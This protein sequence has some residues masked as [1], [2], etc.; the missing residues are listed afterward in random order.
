MLLMGGVNTAWWQLPA[1]SAQPPALVEIPELPPIPIAKD[2]VA[3]LGMG[4]GSSLPDSPVEVVDTQLSTLSQMGGDGKVEVQAVE[5]LSQV[6]A[7]AYYAW[8]VASQTVL[9]EKSSEE[10]LPPA[11]T[12]KLLTAM[13]ALDL[14]EASQQFTIVSQDLWENQLGLIVGESYSRDD[15]LAAL[16]VSSSN[17][18]AYSLA[19]QHPEGISGF[20]RVMNEKA[21]SIGLADTL[22][23][24]PAGFDHPD[25]F[26]TA[27]D[28]SRLAQA[29]LTYPDIARLVA[30]PA[31][32][33]TPQPNQ[34]LIS[35]KSTNALLTN[36][37]TV[38]GIKT[39]TTPLAKEVLISQFDRNG[40]QIEVVVL[41]S[42]QRYVDTKLL[43]DWVLGEY[44]WIEL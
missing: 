39:G 42:Q 33:I 26:S 32:D 2:K 15:L 35:L 8:D 44:A 6:S 21:K 9:A 24:N 1:V 29:A 28:L 38:L 27:I 40:H 20:V 17:E 22:I 19:R 13:V 18:A 10:R 3:L 31:I 12:M 25:Q 30:T 41:G 37:P 16:L 5:P 34:R 4:V 14:Y 43:L 36:D 23:Q 11:S 7:T